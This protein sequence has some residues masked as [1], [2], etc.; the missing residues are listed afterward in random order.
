M[1]LSGALLDLQ[2]TLLPSYWCSPA[3]ASP[4]VLN[5]VCPGD[6]VID[7]C[8]LIADDLTGS[9]DDLLD[10]EVL[11]RDPG[12]T[13]LRPV[14]DAATGVIVEVGLGSFDTNPR[15]SLKWTWYPAAPDP[16]WDDLTGT[17]DGDPDVWLG[18]DGWQ[19]ELQARRP[20]DLFVPVAPAAPVDGPGSAAGADLAVLAR[21]SHDGGQTFRLC[22]LDGF[23]D[24][25][26]FGA[27]ISLTA[28]VCAP[29]PCRAPQAATCSGSTLIGYTSPGAC[30]A[31]EGEASCA[32]ATRTFSC[33]SY[34]GC[35]AATATCTTPPA[36]PSTP[37]ALVITELMRDSSLPLPDRGEWV[38]VRN[39]GSSPLDLRGCVF[40]VRTGP[41]GEAVAGAPLTGPIPELI[42]GGLNT[43]FVQSQI[44]AENAGIPTFYG[45]LRPI[46]VELP[47]TVGSLELACN[48]TVIDT[49]SWGPGWPGSRGVS[50]QLDRNRTDSTLNDTESNW[51]PAPF[52]YGPQILLGSPGATN[53]TCP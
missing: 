46:G 11:L 36:S 45:P 10:F 16:M 29:N 52:S 23:S 26:D 3:P 1:Q 21:V 37:G 19:A 5:L 30:T 48:G 20:A 34:G 27:T 28:G 44:A 15:T 31:V 35:N 7:D 41:S 50:M 32:Y 51:C 25:P 53:A 12:V 38:E 42:S 8:R 6:G 43:I 33:F 18:W 14:T 39:P 17:G 49:V 47:N 4:R 40:S 9:A 13:D 2:D 24:D 22:G